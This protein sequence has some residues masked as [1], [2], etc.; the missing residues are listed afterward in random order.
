MPL[1]LVIT[2]TQRTVK[3]KGERVGRIQKIRNVVDKSD[4][5]VHYQGLREAMLDAHHLEPTLAINPN[6]TVIFPKGQSIAGKQQ[7]PLADWI[8]YCKKTPAPPAIS[9]IELGTSEVIE[10]VEE[11]APPAL[12]PATTTAPAAKPAPATQPT[13]TAAPAPTK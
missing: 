8:D 2:N 6:A 4:M 3:Q 9:T 11:D 5:R 12:A 1:D 7:L 10:E 13:A